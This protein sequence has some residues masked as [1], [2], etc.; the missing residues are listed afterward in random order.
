MP[1]PV[2]WGN[3]LSRKFAA[4]SGLP[5]GRGR[6]EFLGFTPTPI[7][8][9]FV[10]RGFVYRW[11]CRGSGGVGVEGLFRA[12]TATQKL[13]RSET[14]PA[15]PKVSRGFG[16]GDSVLLSTGPSLLPLGVCPLLWLLWLWRFCF[17]AASDQVRALGLARGLVSRC[18]RSPRT[19]GPRA[20]PPRC[21]RTRKGVSSLCLLGR[22]FGY[23]SR[24]LL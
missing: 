11:W 8:G 12:Y 21:R 16:G 19:P 18:C 15:S 10:W 22:G 14:A 4:A 6:G 3:S 9:L 17:S 7:P 23:P 5:G 13:F 24:T 1:M 20:R 2:P